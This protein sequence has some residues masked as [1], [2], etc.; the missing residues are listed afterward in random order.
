[1]I[2]DQVVPSKFFPPT[3]PLGR[4][5]QNSWVKVTP[6]SIGFDVPETNDSFSGLNAFFPLSTLTKYKIEA[7]NQKRPSFLTQTATA[8]TDIWYIVLGPGSQISVT[9]EAIE[10]DSG[11]AYFT[12][13]YPWVITSR[14]SAGAE[15]CAFIAHIRRFVS[16]ENPFDDPIGTH[17]VFWV[18]DTVRA[19]HLAT[20]SNVLALTNDA[21]YVRWTPGSGSAISSVQLVA[22]S[23]ARDFYTSRMA[24]AKTMLSA[25]EEQC[26]HGVQSS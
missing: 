2:N 17:R 10:L 11:W 3:I 23:P 22:G 18:S 6:L 7:D 20:P 15:G 1:M 19:I 26:D 9:D 4:V 24:A 13:Y 14:S 25:Q 5:I 12:G 8:G 16:G 21:N